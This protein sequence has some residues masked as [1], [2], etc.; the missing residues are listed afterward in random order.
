MSVLKYQLRRLQSAW[1]GEDAATL[2][3]LQRSGKVVY[4]RG[5]YGVP[6]IH[7][8]RYDPARL[9]VGNYCS[10]GGTYLLGGQHAV[11]HVTT[12]PLRINLGLD[13]AGTDGNPALRGDIVVGSD[14]WTGYGSWIMSGLT[15]GDGAVVA[16]GAVVT[17]DV[18][19]YAIVGGTP[20]KV[21]KYRFSEEQ[22]AALL[23]IK[24][25]DWPDDE[26]RRAVPYLA[27]KDIDRFIEYA[28]KREH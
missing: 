6:T 13:G 7:E 19:P 26:I 1:W 20:A 11:E 17:K 16:T 5:S 3:R 21:I 15:I 9:I 27:A 14:V 8:F 22:R 12:Y 24:W 28:H 23:E 2:R 25:W 10:I 18:P 4:G